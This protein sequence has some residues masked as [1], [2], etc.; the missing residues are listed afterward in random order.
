MKEIFRHLPGYILILMVS[1]NSQLGIGQAEE[2][3]AGDASE[4]DPSPIKEPASMS[5]TFQGTV[6]EVIDVS[7]HVYLHIYT[8]EKLI[9]VTA[10]S[11]EGHPGDMIIVPPGVPVDNF[12][13]KRLNRKFERMYFVGGI[14]QV[15]ERSEGQQSQK[16]PKNPPPANPSKDEPMVHPP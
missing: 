10:P 12:Y 4:N 3:L 1:F 6:V 8:G 11:F 13:S 2:G 16:L 5:E 7:M 14:R 9:W 15:D